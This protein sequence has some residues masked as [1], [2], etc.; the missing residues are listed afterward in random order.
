[1]K[2][3]IARLLIAALFL[4]ALAFPAAVAGAS[5][6]NSPLQE[7]NTPPPY[8]E[9]PLI[10][11]SSYY[12]DVDT[13]SPNTTFTL[14][15]SVE[16]K[17]DEEARNLIFSFAGDDFLPRDSGGVQA[18]GGLSEQGSGSSSTVVSQVFTANTSLW[19]RVNGTIPVNLSYIG[20]D[21]GVSFSETFTIT[22]PVA[23][24]SGSS[25]TA[26]PT[27]TATAMPRA[28]LV[29]SGYQTDVDPLQP[30]SI[31][32]INL[33]I[34]N[35]GNGNARDVT[36]ILGG[37]SAG[38]AGSGTP[39]PGGI[40]GSGADLS[41]FAPIGSSNLQF[42]DDI[43]TG[44]SKKASQKLIVNVS[45]NPGAYALK[46]SFVYT[47]DQG[48]RAVD[49]QVIT[50]LIYQLPQIEVNFYRDPGPISVMQ[51][52]MLPL[53]VV[54]LSRK[55][56]VMGN[57]TVS[58]E[59]AELMNNVTLI[60]TLDAGGYFPLDVMYIPQNPG[61]QE[62]T[63]NISYTDDFNQP[64]T[65]TQTIEVNVQEAMQVDPGMGPGMDP[66]SGMM[67]GE[68]GTWDPGMDPGMNISTGEETFW[69]KV[70]RFLKGLIGLDSGPQQ[71]AG[72]DMGPGEFQEEPMPV[73]VRPLG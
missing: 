23:G 61:P 15:L 17:G 45:A 57:M 63:V 67:P 41:T 34:Q 36:M 27:P 68:E 62:I 37:G 42:L 13:I 7:D 25:A 51:P 50:L 65:I 26:T 12:L 20:K 10:V 14:Y 52:N 30:G 49:D 29:V 59:N 32:T 18:V 58:A 9:R 72:P 24:W 6:L 11:I 55:S 47:D 31:F 46:L 3:P 33:N 28:Q 53:Q 4:T 71:P 56:A 60:G 70:L 8:T 1:M 48:N 66:G 5:A 64:R 35:L 43:L 54:N 19:G 21:S 16:N 22:L 38:D 39:V 73:P 69:Q 2:T 44:E 40:S